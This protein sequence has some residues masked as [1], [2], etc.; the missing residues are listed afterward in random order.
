MSRKI[1]AWAVRRPDIGVKIFAL[2][3]DAVEWLGSNEGS[4]L[5]LVPHDPKVVA[6]V[7]AAIAWF[8]R[9]NHAAGALDRTVPVLDSVGA[10]LA[11]RKKA[12][13]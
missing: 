5:R 13:R 6:V 4:L 1:D 3:E 2:K 8:R 9:F 7:R 11:S 12:K 10:L